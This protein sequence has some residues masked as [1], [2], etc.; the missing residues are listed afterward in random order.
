ME[1]TITLEALWAIFSKIKRVSYGSS[2]ELRSEFK[3]DTEMVYN[4]FQKEL[5]AQAQICMN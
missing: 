3:V 4:C 1:N 5:N 2:V